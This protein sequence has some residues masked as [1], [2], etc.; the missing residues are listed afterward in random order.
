MAIRQANPGIQLVNI[1][2]IVRIGGIFPVDS[3]VSPPDSSHPVFSLR[4][5][6]IFLLTST[7]TMQHFDCADRNSPLSCFKIEVAGRARS[8]TPTT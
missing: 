8:G 5:L 4:F 6:C 7:G 2:C 3:G 1:D